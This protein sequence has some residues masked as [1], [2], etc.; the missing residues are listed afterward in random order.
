MC[1]HNYG[2]ELKEEKR[3]GWRKEGRVQGREEGVR[4]GKR[5][6]PMEG[7]KSREGLNL[8]EIQ[9]LK[10]KREIFPSWDFYKGQVL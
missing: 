5:Q 3:E 6:A 4:E 7:G 9:Y 8:V 10:L 1:T 2:K